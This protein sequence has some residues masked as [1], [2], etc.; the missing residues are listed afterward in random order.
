MWDDIF[1][2][3]AGGAATGGAIGGPWGAGIGGVIGGIGGYFKGKGKKKQKQALGQARAQLEE[4]ART[5]REKRS[6]DMQR[7]MSYFGPVEDE[8]K[9]LY[10]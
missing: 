5:Q 9:R 3:S 2:G 7:A 6:A 1:M 10:G 4:F 8:M